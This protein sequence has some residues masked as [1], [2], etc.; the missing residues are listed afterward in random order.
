MYVSDA[1]SLGQDKMSGGQLD[2]RLA[3]INKI[4]D[5]NS[6]VLKDF[7]E[8]LQYMVHEM[9][10]FMETEGYED[11]FNDD[12]EINHKSLVNFVRRIITDRSLQTKLNDYRRPEQEDD[13]CK[14]GFSFYEIKK[15]L[16]I[17]CPSRC[18][19]PCY[20]VAKDE[21][22]AEPEG[23][24]RFLNRANRHKRSAGCGDP[25]GGDA[26][27]GAAGGGDAGGGAPGTPS[28]KRP[29][30]GSDK[31]KQPTEPEG[32]PRGGA[33]GGG[34]A[35]GGAPGTEYKSRRRRLPDWLSSCKRPCYGSDKGKQPTEPEGDP[36]GGDAGGG[37]PVTP[38]Y[39]NEF[40][41]IPEVRPAQGGAGGSAR[42]GVPQMPFNTVCRKTFADIAFAAATANMLDPD[43]GFHERLHYLNSTEGQA[44]QS[45]IWEVIGSF[46]QR[47]RTREFVNLVRQVVLPLRVI[48][49]ESPA[50][51]GADQG[52]SAQGGSAQGSSGAEQGGSAQGSSGADQGGSGADQ[53]NRRNICFVC[54]EEEIYFTLLHGD[55]AHDGVCKRCAKE[56]ALQP[57]K[58]CPMCRETITKQIIVYRS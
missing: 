38:I 27:G 16:E 48:Q 23:A 51:S 43:D 21:Q 47:D 15:F 50:A 14:G 35:G 1:G 25:R 10:Y 5:E 49:T 29:C 45:F 19:R 4:I 28:C 26:G 20:G 30:Y 37:A 2:K 13:N 42:A 18:K 3:E 44:T 32:D 22:P 9:Q 8:V 24:T 31:G 39:G 40:D 11:F 58:P 46:D 57:G 33:A 17:Y 52:G 41:S 55:N 36:R 34:D 7:T 6:R 53:G 12:I 56:P 54:W